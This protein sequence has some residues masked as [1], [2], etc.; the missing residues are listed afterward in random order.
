[1]EVAT[2]YGQPLPDWIRIKGAADKN[3]QQVLELQI[4]KGESSAIALAIET[5]GCI[6]ILDDYKA[7]KVAEKLGL[8]VTGTIGVII[9]AKLKGILSSI[10]PYLNKINQTD[11]HLSEDIEREALKQAGE[12]S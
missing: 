3:L 9:K 4:D 1:M 2:E 7:R 8:E 6:I 11:F 10:K 5:P 12:I